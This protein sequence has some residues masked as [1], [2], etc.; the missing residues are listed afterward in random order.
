MPVQDSLSVPVSEELSMEVEGV[1]PIAMTMTMLQQANHSSDSDDMVIVELEQETGQTGS[2]S[3]HEVDE[4]MPEQEEEVG[5]ALCED[6][7]GEYQSEHGGLCI[8]LLV[9]FKTR[10]AKVVIVA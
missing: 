6:E 8:T 1:E 3:S 7:V 2:T 10:V 4:M 9:H 5:V